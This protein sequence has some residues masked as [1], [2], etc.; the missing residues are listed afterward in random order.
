[1]PFDPI[2]KNKIFKDVPEYDKIVEDKHMT[3]VFSTGPH[4]HIETTVNGERVDP[5]SVWA[6]QD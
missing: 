3:K 2:C 1:M 5:L 4:V 6:P